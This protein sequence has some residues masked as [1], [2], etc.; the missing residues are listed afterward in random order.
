[1]FGEG[2]DGGARGAEKPSRVSSFEPGSQVTKPFVFLSGPGFGHGLLGILFFLGA[3]GFG[4]ESLSRFGAL[5][6]S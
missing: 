3:P 5:S 4:H 1:M 6:I 2:A